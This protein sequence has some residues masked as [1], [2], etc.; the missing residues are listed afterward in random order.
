MDSS[1]AHALTQIMQ[2]ESQVKKAVNSKRYIKIHQYI[3]DLKTTQGKAIITIENPYKMGKKIKLRKNS[4]KAK[5]Y[6][7]QY[8]LMLYEYHMLF[9]E[10]TKRKNRYKA[11]L[12]R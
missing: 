2:I 6:L 1:R 7:K 3:R 12:F 4:E 5:E 10:L 8:E 9:N 11:E